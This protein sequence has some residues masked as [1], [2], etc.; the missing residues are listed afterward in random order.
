MKDAKSCGDTQAECVS[1]VQLWLKLVKAYHSVG[2]AV[3]PRLRKSGLGESDF[4]VLEALLHKG[5]LPVNT[6][7]PKVYLTPGSISVAVDRLLAKKLVTRVDSPTDRRVRVVALTP[8][9]RRLIQK[10]FAQHAEDLERIAGVLNIEDRTA[11]ARALKTLG[12]H[13]DFLAAQRGTSPSAPD[14]PA[15]RSKSV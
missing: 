4:R 3:A 13:A 7:G 14:A 6:L 9:G 10:L 1:G 5:A 8:A 2:S 11:A 15:R 12:K